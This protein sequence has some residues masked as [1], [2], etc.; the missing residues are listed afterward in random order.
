MYLP[1]SSLIP[2][3]AAAMSP[4]Y[5][6]SC[7][8]P[9]EDSEQKAGFTALARTLCGPSY[10][11]S[12]ASSLFDKSNHFAKFPIPNVSVAICW[13]K[14]YGHLPMSNTAP[15]HTAHKTNTRASFVI[16]AS[17]LLRH[18]VYNKL[19][20]MTINHMI[21]SVIHSEGSKNSLVVS[22]CSLPNMPIK[23]MPAPMATPFQNH[24]P[25]TNIANT[26]TSI[27]AVGFD[28][29][30]RPNSTLD[31]STYFVD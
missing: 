4:V 21:M 12:F 26:A 9:S 16:T 8:M 15:I 23:V 30:A 24:I 31:N 7:V 11:A 10:S 20:P 5:S 17:V 6:S 18:T 14:T 28:I 27:N 19:N 29:T 22:T 13:Y 1:T 25:N 3:P 2:L